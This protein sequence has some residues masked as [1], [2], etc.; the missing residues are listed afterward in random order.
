[1]GKFLPDD[2]SRYYRRTTKWSNQIGTGPQIFGSR[3]DKTVA[4][5][6]HGRVFSLLPSDIYE[7]PEGNSQIEFHATNDEPTD[8]VT[9]GSNIN[10]KLKLYKFLLD[11]CC[12]D[13]GKGLFSVM[14][15]LMGQGDN[16]NFL[17]QQI[18]ILR[19][20]YLNRTRNYAVPMNSFVDYKVPPADQKFHNESLPTQLLRFRTFPLDKDRVGKVAS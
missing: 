12:P 2:L 10:Y 16:E 13:D 3:P 19:Q 1:M 6:T 20:A 4:D 9:V 17:D 18:S 5:S 15:N 7:K 11:E 8:K 14:I